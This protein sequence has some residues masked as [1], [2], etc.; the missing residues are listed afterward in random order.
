[1]KELPELEGRM[2]ASTSAPTTGM[3]M[4]A[5]VGINRQSDGVGWS[6]EVGREGWM[7]EGRTRGGGCK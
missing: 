7:R 1:M 2:E 5:E 3:G 4:T 6:E